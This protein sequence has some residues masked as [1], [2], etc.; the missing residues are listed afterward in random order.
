[1]S[2]PRLSLGGRGSGPSYILRMEPLSCA[3][4][5]S[6]EALLLCPPAVPACGDVA[7]VLKSS[8]G[9]GTNLDIAATDHVKPIA[10]TTAI[11]IHARIASSLLRIEFGEIGGR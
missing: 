9:T 1:M 2:E 8:M 6:A 11:P 5:Q 4:G 7:A 3:V 10:T